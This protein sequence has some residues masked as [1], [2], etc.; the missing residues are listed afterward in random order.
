MELEFALVERD[1]SQTKE[2]DKKL[3]EGLS[4]AKKKHKDKRDAYTA[5]R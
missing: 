4:E 3:A 1:Q 2:A 5:Q